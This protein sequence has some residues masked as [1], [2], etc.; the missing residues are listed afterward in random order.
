MFLGFWVLINVFVQKFSLSQTIFMVFGSSD[1]T[2]PVPF[3]GSAK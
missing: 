3:N 2:A 1:I